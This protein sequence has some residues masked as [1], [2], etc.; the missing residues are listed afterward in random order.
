MLF[1]STVKKSTI[2]KKTNRNFILN[3][4]TYL[5]AYSWRDACWVASYPVVTAV[6]LYFWAPSS[7]AAEVDFAEEVAAVLVVA[8]VVVVVVVEVQVAAV[9]DLEEVV[10]AV[11]VAVGD[12]GEH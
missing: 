8:A 3:G 12:L 7:P 2:S 6:D 11:A 4:F 1:K 5:D 10:A 9:E